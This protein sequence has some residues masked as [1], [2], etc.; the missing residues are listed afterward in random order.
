MSRR[1]SRRRAD[2]VAV[3]LKV[4]LDSALLATLVRDS[5]A[6]LDAY[7]MPQ[8]ELSLVLCDDAFIQELNRRWRGIA[9]PTDVLSFAMTESVA[10]AAATPGADRLLHPNL[11]GDVIVSL[12]TAARQAE[13]VGHPLAAE[14]RV[15]LVHGFLHLC[16]YDHVEEEDAVEMRVE[17]AE[18]L[19]RLE[20]SASGLIARAA[21][22]G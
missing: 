1:A 14:L 21:A 16:G 10:H 6:L 11:L 17:E 22:A 2:R 4:P 8:G 20:V 5:H 19:A 7:G 18:M 15:L 3:S 12:P 9:T 13:E